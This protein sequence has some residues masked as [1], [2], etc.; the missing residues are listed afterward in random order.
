MVYN[1]TIT[2]GVCQEKIEMIRLSLNCSELELE[3]KVKNSQIAN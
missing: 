1:I 2:R 3:L